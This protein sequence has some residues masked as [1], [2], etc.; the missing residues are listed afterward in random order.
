MLV[1]K[2]DLRR[3]EPLRSEARPVFGGSLEWT[4]KIFVG[5]PKLHR[6]AVKEGGYRQKSEDSGQERDLR[7]LRKHNRCADQAAGSPPSR[8]GCLR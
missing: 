5:C 4:G 7:N 1:E 2:L 6:V 3:S 8:T